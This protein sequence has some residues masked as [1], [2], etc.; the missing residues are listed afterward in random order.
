MSYTILFCCWGVSMTDQS[1]DG[2]KKFIFKNVFTFKGCVSL[3]VYYVH[4]KK[5]FDDERHQMKEI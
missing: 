2:S 5:M 4:C 1:S 3:W